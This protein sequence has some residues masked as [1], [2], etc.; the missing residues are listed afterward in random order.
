MNVGTVIPMT[1]NIKIKNTII[2]RRLSIINNIP[3][4]QRGIKEVQD[5]EIEAELI[6]LL[7]TLT[8]ELAELNGV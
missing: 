8:K 7:N 4:V 1:K 5:K 3:Q 2:N 6:L